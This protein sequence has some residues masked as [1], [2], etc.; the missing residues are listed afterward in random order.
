MTEDAFPPIQLGQGD[1][2]MREDGKE[3]VVDERRGELTIFKA[4]A[5]NDPEFFSANDQQLAE[6]FSDARL[7]ELER[8]ARSLAA[9]PS[10]AALGTRVRHIPEKYKKIVERRIAYALALR[11]APRGHRSGPAFEKIRLETAERLGDKSPPSA[12][13]IRQWLAR[14]ISCDHD[15]SALLPHHAAPRQRARRLNPL[16]S[17]T[18]EWVISNCY[19][20]PLRWTAVRTYQELCDRLKTH[21]ASDPDLSKRKLVL[22]SIATLRRAIRARNPYEVM[23][24]RYGK[25]AADRHFRIKRKGRRYQRA[26]EAVILDATELDIFAIDEDGQ[27]R[28]RPWLI[29]V[30]CA[31]TRMIIGFALTIEPPSAATVLQALRNAMAPKSYVEHLY[32]YIRRKWVCY[33]RIE[34][35]IVDVGPENLN[36]DVP[37]ALREILTDVM[38]TAVDSPEQK[39]IG[40]RMFGT[41]NEQLIHMLPG[42][43]RSN[44]KDLNKGRGR[45]D[46][47]EPAK[48]ASYTIEEL[49]GKLHKYFIDDYPYRYHRELGCRPIEAWNEAV[50]QHPVRPPPPDAQLAILMS[51][52]EERDLQHYGINLFGIVYRSDELSELRPRDI[53][54]PSVKVVVKYDPNDIW[55]IWVLDK[56]RRQYIPAY[57]ECEDL[58]FGMSERQFKRIREATLKKKNNPGPDDYYETACELFKEL[59]DRPR[60]E[61]SILRYSKLERSPS[62]PYGNVVQSVPQMGPVGDLLDE[63]DPPELSREPGARVVPLA[64]RVVE[65]AKREPEPRDDEDE[66]AYVRIIPD[67]TREGPIGKST[68]GTLSDEPSAGTAE[69]QPVT[70]G[71]PSEGG[72]SAEGRQH[73]HPR[74]EQPDGIADGAGTSAPP[75]EGQGPDSS[76]MEVWQPKRPT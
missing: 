58:V 19:M 41:I 54:K 33:G 48:Q 26:L 4:R 46:K 39:G 73:R 6:L 51:K 56:E 47:I 21:W 1:S 42:T 66:P 70:Q 44:P 62:M 61:K 57:A 60:V 45:R 43:T 36:D 63:E 32:P 9:R 2:V 27:T 40:E 18:V 23:A 15:P 71:D 49:R 76:G 35:V 3:F 72:P 37:R 31:A 16:I 50:R 8:G 67:G 69:P 13:M 12:R 20:S 65:Q 5:P 25:H 55:R 68:S 74:K 7:V 34:E 38:F 59:R 14:L 53:D 17:H 22:P 75:S 11:D 30:I 24:A 52:T 10:M 29:I 28:A 64:E